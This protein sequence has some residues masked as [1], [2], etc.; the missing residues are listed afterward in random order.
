VALT[1]TFSPVARLPVV[2]R[3]R[4]MARLRCVADREFDGTVRRAFVTVIY[5]AAR[6][7]L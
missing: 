7:T 2:E 5:T 1:A 6:P 3:D 4:C